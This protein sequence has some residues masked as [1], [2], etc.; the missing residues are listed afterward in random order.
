[1]TGLESISATPFDQHAA[2]DPEVAFQERPETSGDKDVMKKSNARRLYIKGEDLRAFGYTVGCPRCTH[3]RRYGPGLTTK[4]QSDE[5]RQRITDELSETPEGLRRISA[6]DERIN[7]SVAE[8]IE[9]Q[10]QA[11]HVHGAATRYGQ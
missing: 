6:A 2:Q 3:E 10:D 5:C 4:G 1:M 8:D 9:R 7:R 11:P